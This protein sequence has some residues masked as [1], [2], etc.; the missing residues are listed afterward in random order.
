MGM[1]GREDRLTLFLRMVPTLLLHGLL[2]PVGTD[3]LP[4]P[5]RGRRPEEAEK[6]L[7]LS[8]YC[9]PLAPV[10]PLEMGPAADY[11]R[12]VTVPHPVSGW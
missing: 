1:L 9:L 3:V 11:K 6:V 4:L 5:R 7:G 8:W 12:M 2:S 10:S